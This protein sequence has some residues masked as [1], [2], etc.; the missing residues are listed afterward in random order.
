MDGKPIINLDELEVYVRAIESLFKQGKLNYLEQQIVLDQIKLRNEFI[1][2]KQ[3]AN[4]MMGDISLTE[5]FKRLKRERD[6]PENE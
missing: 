3:Q 5:L 2:K 1:Q 6:K 4:D